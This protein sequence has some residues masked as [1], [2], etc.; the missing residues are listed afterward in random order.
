M[1]NVYS[2][3]KKCIFTVITGGYDELLEP[4]IRSRDWDYICFTDTPNIKSKNWKIRPI[5][6][7]DLQIACPKRRAN[8]VVMKYYEY[9]SDEYDICL[10]IDGN[11]KIKK[12]LD[13]FLQ[14]FKYDPTKHDLMIPD[15]PDRICIYKEADAIIRL[16]KDNQDKVKKHI[17]I[18]RNNK[19]PIDRGLY[20]TCIMVITRK[21][22][23]TKKL[24]DK[25]FDVYM[26]MPSKRDQLSLSYATWLLN[27]E[28]QILSYPPPTG[29]VGKERRPFIKYFETARQH[30]KVAPQ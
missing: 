11:I 2:N 29:S 14:Q 1:K 25:W 6:E 15:H 3:Y 13:D 23:M 9:L 10:Y 26:S 19:Y 24:Y 27:D 16:N 12:K 22:E 4:A 30:K 7:K 5:H 17:D 20:E 18:I 28:P 8:A 21:S